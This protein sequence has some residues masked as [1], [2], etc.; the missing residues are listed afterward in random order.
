MMS[1]ISWHKFPPSRSL[2]HRL[3]FLTPT[4]TLHCAQIHVLFPG[5]VVALMHNV[6][7]SRFSSLGGMYLY[8]GLCVSQESRRHQHN[9]DCHIADSSLV[10]FSLKLLFYGVLSTV[11]FRWLNYLVPQILHLDLSSQKNW[12]LQRPAILTHWTFASQTICPRGEGVGSVSL[13]PPRMVS[14]RGTFNKRNVIPSI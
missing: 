14:Y 10:S 13:M 9:G 1:T 5:L 2:Q 3:I 8:P 4:S 7:H 6:C 11:G 12:T